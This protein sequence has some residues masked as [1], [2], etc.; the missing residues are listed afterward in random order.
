MS[1]FK[2]TYDRDIVYNFTIALP[3]NSAHGTRLE[4]ITFMISNTRKERSYEEEK[5]A[6]GELHTE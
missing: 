6:A 5:T 2:S 1:K 4:M 3:S